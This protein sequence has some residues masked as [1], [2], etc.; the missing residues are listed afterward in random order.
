[1]VHVK[2]AGRRLVHLWIHAAIAGRRISIEMEKF[3]VNLP[4]PATRQTED[5]NEKGAAKHA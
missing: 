2:Q 3:A 5:T 1:M 4:Q